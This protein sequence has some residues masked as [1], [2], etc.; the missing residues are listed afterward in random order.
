MSAVA[1]ASAS[2]QLRAT[3][4]TEAGEAISGAPRAGSIVCDRRRP[5]T[6]T[7]WR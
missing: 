2:A 3:T 5:C 7:Q 4:V 6:S 1:Q